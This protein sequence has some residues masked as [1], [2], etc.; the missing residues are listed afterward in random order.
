[1]QG[2]QVD[3]RMAKGHF[4]SGRGGGQIEREGKGGGVL[5]GRSGPFSAREYFRGSSKEK[6]KN[7]KK[8]NPAT[9]NEIKRKREGERGKGD[10]RSDRKG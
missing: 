5:S 4:P 6:K 2:V 3:K 9:Q 7:P 1:M 10:N 8:T